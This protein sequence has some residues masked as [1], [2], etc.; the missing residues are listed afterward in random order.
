MTSAPNSPHGSIITCISD[1]CLVSTARMARL[2]RI[3]G[4][5]GQQDHRGVAV[6]V[7]VA[8]GGLNQ[9]FDFGRS[10]VFAGLLS[11][12]SVGE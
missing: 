5:E 8:L 4:G 9:S 6:T 2:T 10:E 12:P 1:H 11:S 7:A 3:C